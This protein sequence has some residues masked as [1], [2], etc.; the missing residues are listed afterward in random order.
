MKPH[1][2]VL[3]IDLR[4]AG[5][6]L[7]GMSIVEQLDVASPGPAC[8]TQPTQNAALTIETKLKDMYDFLANYM[9]T[10]TEE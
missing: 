2:T 7:Q 10:I 3:Q 8:C 4:Q 5:G 9:L 1:Y 6:D